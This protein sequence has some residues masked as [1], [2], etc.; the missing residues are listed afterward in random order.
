MGIELLSYVVGAGRDGVMHMSVCDAVLLV[1]G[2]RFAEHSKE[3]KGETR[4]NPCRGRFV[5]L[6][7]E[8]SRSDATGFD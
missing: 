8:F 6:D 5:R 4:V 1:V 3:Q 2:P 7:N